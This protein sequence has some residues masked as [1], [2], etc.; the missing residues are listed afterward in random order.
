MSAPQNI[1]KPSFWLFITETYRAIR[2][3]LTCRTFLKNY[4]VSQPITDGHTILVLP[5]FMASDLSTK[6]LRHFLKING[7][8]T[9]GWT[10]GTNL[11]NLE[12]LDIIAKQ[13]D[14]L[15][16]Q[17][18]Q[19]I[20][21]IG[22]SLGGV[23]ARQLAKEKADKIRQVITLGSPFAAILAPNNANRTFSFISWLKGYPPIDEDFVAEL[24]KPI[25]V[26]STAIYSKEDGIVP[27][28]SCID[29]V[30]DKLTQNVEV[31]GSHLG[32]GVNVTVLPILLDRLQYSEENWVHYGQNDKQ[33]VDS[34]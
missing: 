9:H 26:P 19:K 17:K 21:L 2:E 18:G 31:K 33:L 23:Y 5:G 24:A 10:L 34:E 20:S 6:P 28:E 7:Y 32:L 15:Y 3:Y 29:K 13:I 4:S 30:E 8:Q 16:A 11:A 14:Q 1:K 22:W 25:S 12:E 27:W